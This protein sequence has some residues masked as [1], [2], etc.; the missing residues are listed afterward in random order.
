[1]LARLTD[2]LR[3]DLDSGDL[4]QARRDWLPAHL[5]YERLGAAYGAFGDLDDAINGLPNGLPQGVDDPEWTGFH[6]I[7][8]GL[9]HGQPASTLSALGDTLAADV[10][11]L[12]ATFATAQIDPLEI[13]IRAHEITENAVQFELTGE[14]DFGSDSN[15]ATIAANLQGTV[16]VLDILTPLLSPRDLQLPQLRALLA[17]TQADLAA[18]GAVLQ[19]LPRA[20]R[21]L[22]NADLSQLAEELA[23]VASILEPRRVTQ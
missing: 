8:Y 15:I 9:W 21:E 18:S 14:T 6:R 19:E 16:T 5:E 12:G 22:L 11:K 2:A 7:E 10:G 1:M 17:K 3:A 20:R 13:S 4:A 23:P